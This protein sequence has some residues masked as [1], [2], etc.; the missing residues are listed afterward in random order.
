L[1]T[2]AGGGRGGVAAAAGN[3]LNDGVCASRGISLGMFDN[4]TS[5][6]GVPPPCPPRSVSVPPY[7]ATTLAGL[8]T[9]SDCSA[10]AVYGT[11]RETTMSSVGG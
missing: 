9:Q 11:G 10:A 7:I 4:E 5:S 3:K 1:L 8:V 2:F 6:G